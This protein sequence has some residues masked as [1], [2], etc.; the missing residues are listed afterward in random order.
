[1]IHVSSKKEARIISIVIRQV[2]D[3]NVAL[4]GDKT[5]FYFFF[6]ILIELIFLYITETQLVYL[7]FK[8]FRILY[9]I[10]I[11]LYFMLKEVVNNA[12]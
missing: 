3:E 8:L 10:I 7:G 11:K 9:R 4:Q 12:L 6:N 2:L 1:M 5:C